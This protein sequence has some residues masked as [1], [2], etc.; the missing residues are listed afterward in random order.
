MPNFAIHDGATVH[1]VI[2]CDTQGLAEELTG[3]LAL[4]TEGQ[5]WIGWTLAEGEWRPPQPYSS[6]VWDGSEWVAPVP[7][8]DEGGPWIWDE[9]TRSWVEVAG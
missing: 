6:W 3:M 1:N 7:M 2:V 9:A 8:P 5:P 4:E